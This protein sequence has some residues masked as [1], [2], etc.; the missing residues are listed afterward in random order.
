MNEITK[1]IAENLLQAR[2][3]SGMSQQKLADA[4]GL[5][6]NTVAF[7]EVQRTEIPTDQLVKVADLLKGGN[8]LWFFQD[9]KPKEAFTPEERAVIMR[10]AELLQK[11]SGDAQ[12]LNRS[13]ND[14]MGDLGDY[15]KELRDELAS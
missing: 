6:K 14:Q 7:W 8:W 1:R 15:M 10:A 3:N 12:H 9:N 13:Y 5:H 2:K 11:A 4:L